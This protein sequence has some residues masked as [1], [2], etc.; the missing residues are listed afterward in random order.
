MKFGGLPDKISIVYKSL[1]DV[2]PFSAQL[3]MIFANFSNVG[4]GREL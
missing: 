2:R 3:W 4:G 1:P